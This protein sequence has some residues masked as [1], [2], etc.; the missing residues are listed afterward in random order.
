MSRR[1]YNRYMPAA[2]LA[3]SALAWP[4]L[5]G[6]H[7]QEGV[8]G[9]LASG[10]LHPLTGADHMLAMVAVGLWGAVL[11][12][13]AI[14]TLPV[15]FPLVMA[16]GGLLGMAG[17]PLP[18]PEIFIALSALALGACVAGR[19]RLPLAAAMAVVAVFAIFHG[20]AHGAELPRAANAVAYGIGFVT[21]TGLLHATGIAIGLLARRPAGLVAVRALGAAISLAGLWFLWQA[22]GGRA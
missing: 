12:A 6:A 14:W 13:P 11:G 2:I 10:L 21:S 19:V 15:T 5:A 9:G 1:D 22:T 20:H 7:T 17:V 3:A 18:A 4:G 16:L 8:A